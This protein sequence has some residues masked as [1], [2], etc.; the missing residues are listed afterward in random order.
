MALLVGL[1]Y[2]GPEELF[3]WANRGP[4]QTSIVLAVQRIGP[5]W[6]FLFVAMGVA[7]IGAA[8][9]RRWMIH[10]HV[11]AVFGWIFY[12]TSVLLGSGLS[13]P[14]APIVSGVMALGVAGIH[15]ALIQAHQEVGNT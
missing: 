11:L 12:G 1:V 6:S 5:V 9:M 7:L 2:F 8:T 15:Y 13:E 3:R 14:P 10:A 4:Q